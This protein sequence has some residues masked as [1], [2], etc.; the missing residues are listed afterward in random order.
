MD[1]PMQPRR[2]SDDARLD[3]DVALVAIQAAVSAM[4]KVE[5]VDERA[6]M[7]RS[8][9]RELQELRAL[10]NELDIHEHAKT[11]GSASVPSPRTQ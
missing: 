4:S 7:A 10:M 5:D 11:P 9:H 3:V 2:H 1:F 8:V 6:E